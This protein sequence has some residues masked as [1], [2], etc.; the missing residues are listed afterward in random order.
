M[1]I[2]NREIIKYPRTK[3]LEGSKLQKGDEDLSQIPFDALKGRQIVVEEKLDGAN[4]GI[5]FSESYDM[6]LQSRGH[7][8]VGGAGEAEFNR[9][10]VWATAHESMLLDMLEDRY[11]MYG[12]FMVSKHTVFYDRLPHI[13]LEFD[14]Y[15]KST[16]RFLSTPERRRL[17]GDRPIISVPVVYQGLTPRTADELQRLVQPSL[18]KSI[19]WKDEFVGRVRDADYNLDRA[20]KE[21]DQT[22]LSEGLYIKIENEDGVVERL[23]WVR[24]GF[25]QTM[26]QSG[27]HWRD[28]MGIFNT[29]A[30][31]VDIFSPTRLIDWENINRD[32]SLLTR[33]D[34]FKEVS[35]RDR[36][37]CVFCGSPGVDA[38]HIFDRKLFPDGGYYLNNGALVCAKHHLTC[39]NTT[40]SVYDVMR[41]AK[42]ISPVLPPRVFNVEHY[43]KWG[44]ILLPSG[45]RRKGPLAEDE[46]ML[47]A[48][49]SYSQATG[50]YGVFE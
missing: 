5:S 44:N 49:A 29:L 46:G 48:I 37:L 22:N 4:T 2:H 35:N 1:S 25:L 8:L 19:W 47:K 23:K 10:K 24:S 31:W 43:D 12:E 11:I 32:Q 42:I 33:D 7:Y 15:D 36:G 17:I 40:V 39:E 18:A 14:I 13:F 30:P 27:S 6:L 20:W 45:K 3:H 34:F 16:E 50:K 41:K 26:E 9:L 38:H 28:R 21:T